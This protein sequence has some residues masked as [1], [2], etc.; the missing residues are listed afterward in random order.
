MNVSG[1]DTLHRR[2]SGISRRGFLWTGAACLGGM[3][4][5]CSKDTVTGDRP[6]PGFTFGV[7]TDLHYA[8]R[9][10]TG[11][12]YYRDAPDKLTAALE[13]LAGFN[14]A[15]IVELGDFIDLESKGDGRDNLEVIDA[16]YAAAPCP[17]Y[18]V[19][20]NH[21]TATLEKDDFLTRVGL[22]SRYYAFDY[23]GCRFV[24]LD[25]NYLADG[26]DQTPETSDWSG[27]Y[28][29]DVEL[30]WL[31][32]TLAGAESGRAIV[33]VHQPLH[34]FD[35]FTG[36][37]NGP[38]VRAAIEESGNVR[39]VFQGHRHAG[40]YAFINGIHYVTASAM[41]EGPWPE[42]TSYALVTVSPAGT[43]TV[44]GYGTQAS[45]TLEP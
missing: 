10:E 9:G 17:R 11:G 18:Y 42:S 14:P 32:A 30:A 28:V 38:D 29:P 34:D 27:F 6:D 22:H 24:V 36:V 45:Y 2:N 26:S 8:D 31:R 1:I 33:F 19:L 13:T 43:V 39:V 7:V 20:G 5:A 3:L 37:A 41:V 12:R 23:G 44:A 15:F 40:G 35:D 21:D 4:A 25:A 16:V